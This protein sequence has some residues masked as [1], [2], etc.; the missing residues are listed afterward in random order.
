MGVWQSCPMDSETL[1]VAVYTAFATTGRAPD[2]QGLAQRLSMTTQDVHAGLRALH[3]TRHLVLGDDGEIVMAHPFSAVPLGFSV[4]GRKSLW[5]GGCAWDAFAL[6]HVVTDEPDVL[7]ATRCPACDGAH[8]WVVGRDGPPDGEQVAHFLKPA[9]EMWADVVHTCANQRL[10][11]SS[12]CVARWL[13][14]TGNAYGDVLDLATL[15]RLAAHWY[16][17]RLERGYQRR[18]PEAAAA[19]FAQVG[20]SGAFWGLP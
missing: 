11:C 19:Y 7:V 18:E 9:R 14:E 2:V 4:M 17:G 12:G 3:D 8:A 16:D 20:L 15:W 1:R 13:D 5:W 6:P 10:F